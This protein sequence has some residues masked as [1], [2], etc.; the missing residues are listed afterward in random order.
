VGSHVVEAGAVL[1]AELGLLDAGH[2]DKAK[3][4]L[5]AGV[6]DGLMGW[7]YLASTR[8]RLSERI[9]GSGL[10]PFDDERFIRRLAQYRKTDAS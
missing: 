6:D 2:A 8:A 9:F 4:L 3:L 5:E 1:V 10:P 7:S